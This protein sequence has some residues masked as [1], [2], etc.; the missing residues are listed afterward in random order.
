MLHSSGLDPVVR[1][2]PAL[3]ASRRKIGARPRSSAGAGARRRRRRRHRGEG[4]APAGRIR[5]DRPPRRRD[6]LR[7]PGSTKPDRDLQLAASADG[8]QRR[9]RHGRRAERRRAGSRVGRRR[10]STDRLGHPGRQ[11]RPVVRSGGIGVRVGGGAGTASAAATGA[12]RGRGAR[13][14]AG[15]LPGAGAMAGRVAVAVPPGRGSG[16]PSRRRS[17]VELCGMPPAAVDRPVRQHH[18]AVRQRSPGRPC[19]PRCWPAARPGCRTGRRAGRPRPGPSAGTRP[20]PRRAARP[21][22]G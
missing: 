6:R 17:A 20:R 7:R 21:A 13:P 3:P 12:R 22:G 4:G 5:A 19:R 10:A 14:G 9:V 2:E 15:R 16:R 18:D 1:L 11:R 8:L